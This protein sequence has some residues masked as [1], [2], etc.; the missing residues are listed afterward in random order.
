MNDCFRKLTK[1]VK[2][3]PYQE[4]Y[5]TQKNLKKVE[6]TYEIQLET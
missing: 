6:V 1:V 2:H 4:F 5:N 3:K